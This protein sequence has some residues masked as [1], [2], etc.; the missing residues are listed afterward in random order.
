[1][2]TMRAR[3]MMRDLTL[4]LGLSAVLGMVPQAL[5]QGGREA[6][7]LAKVVLHDD[8]G[9]TEWIDD[10]NERVTESRRFDALGNLVTKQIFKLDANGRAREMVLMNA[11]NRIVARTRYGYDEFGRAK[12]QRTYNR[13]GVMIHQLIYKYDSNGNPLPPV[14]RSMVDHQNKREPRAP[15]APL[16]TPNG[17]IKQRVEAE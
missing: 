6:G 2:K 5:A 1:M 12:E 9:R 16:L 3:K 15:M 7:V 17:R 14:E 10:K 11:D 8:G 13:R 4:V